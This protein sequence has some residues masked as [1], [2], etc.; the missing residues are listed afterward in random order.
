MKT[1]FV[2]PSIFEGV[3]TAP[4][5]KP[6]THRAL[7][8]ALISEGISTVIKPLKARDI[9]ATKRACVLLG[10]KIM[11][12]DWIMNLNGGVLKT[13]EDIIDVGNS[14]TTLRFFTAISALA[15]EGYAILTGDESIRRRPMQPLLRALRDLG[16]DCWSSKVNGTA[17]II[18]KCGGMRGGEAKI[19]G[20]ISSQFISALLYASVKSE[21]EVRIIVEGDLVSKPYIDASI[22]VLKRF[23]FE[24]KRSGYELFEVDGPQTGK[25]CSFEVPGD[26]SSAALF[27]AAA[28]L[29]GG[30]VV[31]NGLDQSLPQ[32]D[33]KIIEIIKKFGGRVHVSS[34]LVAVSGTSGGGGGEFDLKESPDLLPIVAA[35]AAK[36]RE[37][38]IIRGVSHARYKESDRLKSISTELRKLGV[39]VEEQRDGLRIKGRKELSGGCALEAHGDHRIFM[40]LVILAASTER[41]CF[42]NGAELA[43][44]SYPSFLEHARILGMK[45]KVVEEEL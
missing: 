29:T 12:E 39:I 20:E 5:S 25:P 24:V 35:M 19:T 16:V 37:E 15:P 3:I 43:E 30:K 45:F 2:K 22:E 1:V 27:M 41:G 7:A 42:I 38:T 34:N 18:V 44:I 11:E 14:G 33:A 26:Y 10:A 40:A 8:A 17:P 36:T 6:Y 21:R 31:I 4:P 23:G 28:Y 9:E 32:A 13:P